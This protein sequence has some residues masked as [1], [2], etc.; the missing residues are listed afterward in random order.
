MIDPLALYRV[1]RW[2]KKLPFTR[3]LGY[4]LLGMAMGPEGALPSF[5]FLLY[6]VDGLA[7]TGILMFSYSL[8]DYFDFLL[9]G[10][11]N[12]LGEC[13]GA[14]RLTRRQALSLILLPLLLP[15]PLSYFP[16]P[17]SFSSSSS[18]SFLPCTPFPS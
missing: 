15:F 6:L 9:E 2:G 12:Y 16:S 10:D 1:K 18:S 14:G 4:P 11:S 3:F 13:L 17:P 8:N 5:P 7:V